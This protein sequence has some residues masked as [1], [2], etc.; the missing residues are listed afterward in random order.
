MPPASMKNISLTPAGAD[1]GLGQNLQ[2]QVE[3][4]TDEARKKRMAMANG[5]LFSPA[6]MSL[7][8]QGLTNG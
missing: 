4:E 1:L 3:D 2:Q 8:G 5:A 7:L 6:S